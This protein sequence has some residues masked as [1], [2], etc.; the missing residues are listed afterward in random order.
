MGHLRHWKSVKE[1][2]MSWAFLFRSPF[3][4]VTSI[5][6]SANRSSIDSFERVRWG[7]QLWH[8]NPLTYCRNLLGFSFSFPF[9]SRFSPSR[10][11]FFHSKLLSWLNFQISCLHRQFFHHIF[12]SFFFVFFG[13][14]RLHGPLGWLRRARGK[15]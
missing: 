12:G 1:S 15:I 7:T 9:V 4:V 3:S 5:T 6:E 8:C 10:H 13:T 14:F 2:A 11:L